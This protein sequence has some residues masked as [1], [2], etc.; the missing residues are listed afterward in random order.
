M[1]STIPADFNAFIF[2]LKSALFFASLGLTSPEINAVPWLSFILIF[3]CAIKIL[4][5][6]KVLK[7][8]YFNYFLL[9]VFHF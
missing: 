4:V 7:K 2:A 1:L 6:E 3:F 9:Q 8:P 5:H